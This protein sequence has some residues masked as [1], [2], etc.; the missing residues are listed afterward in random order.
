ME[1]NAD[2]FGAENGSIEV[3]CLRTPTLILTL[4]YPTGSNAL[5]PALA[6]LA[7]SAFGKRFRETEKS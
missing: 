7:N 2:G 3:R 1:E 6:N 5:A 4:R